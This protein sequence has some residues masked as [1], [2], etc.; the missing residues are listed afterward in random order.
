MKLLQ[1][2]HEPYE[3]ISLRQIKKRG[4]GSNVGQ[5]CRKYSTMSTSRHNN[6]NKDVKSTHS[7]LKNE[8][9]CVYKVRK[10]TKT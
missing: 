8:L 10:I 2:F 7:R 5:L 3:K 9:Q 1:K 4:P 6:N